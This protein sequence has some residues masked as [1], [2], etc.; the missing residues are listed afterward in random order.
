MQLH[1]VEFEFDVYLI[2]INKQIE[3]FLLKTGNVKVSYIE[4]AETCQDVNI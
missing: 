3:I 2:H 4:E 1:F